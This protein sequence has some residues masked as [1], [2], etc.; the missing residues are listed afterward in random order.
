MLKKKRPFFKKKLTVN[1]ALLNEMQ[2]MDIP[3]QEFHP[4]VHAHVD[5]RACALD[6]VLR[7]AR[8]E[9]TTIRARAANE[10]LVRIVKWP[11]NVVLLLLGAVPTAT[12]AFYRS[13]TESDW[14]LNAEL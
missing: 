10:C 11:I 9:C 3:T 2:G 1:K 7:P 6:S 5:Y 8:T 4:F 14:F 12:L 13:I